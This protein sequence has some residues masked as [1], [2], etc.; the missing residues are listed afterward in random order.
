MRELK[1]ISTF[2]YCLNQKVFLLV[3]HL[4]KSLQVSQLSSRSFS[5]RDVRGDRSEGW[6]TLECNDSKHSDEICIAWHG[7]PIFRKLKQE[8][9]FEASLSYIV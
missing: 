7:I 5:S 2:T 3:E 1:E 6:N 4:D 8:L 9:D